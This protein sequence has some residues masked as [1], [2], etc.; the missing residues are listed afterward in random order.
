MSSNPQTLRVQAERALRRQWFPVARS[1]DL[2]TPRSATLLGEQLVVYR[3][4]SGRAVV[5]SSRCIH[6]GADFALGKV[7]GESI[8]CPYHGWRFAAENGRCVH[9]PS[10][11][12]QSKIHPKAAIRTY[13]AVE[14]YAH[15][16]TVLEDPVGDLY[17][18][19]H[20]RG[21]ELDWLAADPLDS[22]TGVAVA[23][24][25]FRDVAHFPFVHEVSMGPSPHVVEPLSVRR[26]GIDVWMDRPLIA[27]D[28]PWAH[29]GNCTMNYHCIA[30]GFATIT[31]DYEKLGKRIV[32]GFPSPMAYDH[33]K[34]F[35][36]VAN[37]RGYR[38]AS[39]EECL[40][41]EDLVYRE[42]MPVAAGIRPREVD[43]DGEAL[44]YSVPADL[45]TLNYR[46]AFREFMERAQR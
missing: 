4:E 8:A 18:P 2:T 14:R 27:G 10:L 38:G 33:V 46:R 31:Y 21:V 44:E 24:E 19:A 42:D 9:I 29:D 20:W 41:I 1:V 23:M 12:D 25:N 34:I 35:W 32:A 17:D 22:E 3:T 7:H 28:G 37:Q 40:R 5:Q 6:R 26:E 11:A 15:V 30:P 13:P 45:F 43:W 36:G 39:L 16:W